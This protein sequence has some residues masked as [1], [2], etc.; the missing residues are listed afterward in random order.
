[1]LRPV[2]FE[3]QVPQIKMD[4]KAAKAKYTDGVLKLTLPKKLGSSPGKIFARLRKHR[5]FFLSGDT[6]S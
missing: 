3:Q 4:V 5:A 1:M 6:A 2:R